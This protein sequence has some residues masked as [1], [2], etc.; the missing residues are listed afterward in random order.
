MVPVGAPALPDGVDTGGDVPP[1]AEPVVD[2]GEDDVVW[3]IAAPVPR[4]VPR[5]S[6]APTRIAVS[7]MTTQGSSGRASCGAYTLKRNSRTS[8]SATT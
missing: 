2:V 1:V 3:A 5:A 7:F 6:E 4:P 8:P